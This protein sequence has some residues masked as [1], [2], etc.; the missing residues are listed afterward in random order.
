MNVKNKEVHLLPDV[1]YLAHPAHTRRTCEIQM[2]KE[3]PNS[4]IKFGFI[5]IY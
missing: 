3:F 1:A 5:V 4:K 2:Q